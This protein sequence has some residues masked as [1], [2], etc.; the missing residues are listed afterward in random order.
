MHEAIVRLLLDKGAATEA[1]DNSGMTPLLWTA[2]HGHEAILQ[3]L[4]ENGV[5]TGGECDHVSGSEVF[6]ETFYGLDTLRLDWAEMG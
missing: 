4:L 2:L 6:Q 5:A 3:L 1:K